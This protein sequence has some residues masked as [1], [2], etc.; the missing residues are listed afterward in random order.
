MSR[1]AQNC[2]FDFYIELSKYHSH[3]PHF[4]SQFHSYSN[5]I[6]L[7]TVTIIIIIIIII[8]SLLLPLSSA[9]RVNALG[10]GAPLSQINSS[11]RKAS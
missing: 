9:E 5:L 4:S 2:N 1:A 8:T 6:L 11:E 7:T 10:Q 3:S